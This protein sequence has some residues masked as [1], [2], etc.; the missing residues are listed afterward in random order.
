[1]YPSLIP[2][3]P[4][5]RTEMLSAPLSVVPNTPLH[6]SHHWSNSRPAERHRG[7]WRNV[8]NLRSLGTLFNSRGRS[9]AEA[10]ESPNDQLEPLDDWSIV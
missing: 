4:R 2:L 3:T 7:Y 1:M 9:R 8:P 5:R 10:T 6:I